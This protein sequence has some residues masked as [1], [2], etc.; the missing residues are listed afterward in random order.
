MWGPYWPLAVWRRDL[1]PVIEGLRDGE[2]DR[3][4]ERE[5][6]GAAVLQVNGCLSTGSFPSW[7]TND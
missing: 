5:F 2:R 6:G 1:D 7:H 4:R 3:E